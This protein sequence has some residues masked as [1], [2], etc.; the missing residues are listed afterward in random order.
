[1]LKH[2]GHQ[3]I[4]GFLRFHYSTSLFHNY[5]EEDLC[6]IYYIV[7]NQ[8]HFICY[9]D[10][11]IPS[12]EDTLGLAFHFQVFQAGITPLE[13][14]ICEL[15]QTTAEPSTIPYGLTEQL[16]FSAKQSTNCLQREL[17]THQTIYLLFGGQP[18]IFCQV[19]V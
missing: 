8:L 15:A 13:T 12:S 6:Q 2:P 3:T 14:P 16:S 18:E 10:F 11:R 19:S 9:T 5:Y 1:M 17:T 4:L 7:I